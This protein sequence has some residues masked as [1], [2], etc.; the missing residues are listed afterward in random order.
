MAQYKVTSLRGG[1]GT[2]AIQY[3]YVVERD[4]DDRRTAFVPS[5]SNER[6]ATSKKTFKV[7]NASAVPRLI[8]LTLAVLI[9]AFLCYNYLCLKMDIAARTTHIE[10]LESNLCDLR[11]ANGEEYDR[12]IESV[13]MEQIRSLA[14]NELHMVYPT[15]EQVV[16]IENNE[17][18][19]VRQFS[20]FK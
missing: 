2:S 7:E 17:D 1:T 19:Y 18:D 13:N 15:E 11:K 10:R 14:L 9:T 12:I 4:D 6:I 20:D 5:K 3:S 16:F 8:Y